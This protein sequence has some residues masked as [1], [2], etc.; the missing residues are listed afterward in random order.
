MFDETKFTHITRNLFL[1]LSAN[2]RLADTHKVIGSYEELIQASKGIV[3]AV[4]ISSE[5]LKKKSFDAV[6]EAIVKIVGSGKTVEVSE[7][8]DEKILGGL[9]VLVGDKFIDLSVATRVNSLT[10]TLDSSA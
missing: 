8:V 10:K 4:V 3:K 9:Q 5:P 6:K 2:G 1:T 7:Q